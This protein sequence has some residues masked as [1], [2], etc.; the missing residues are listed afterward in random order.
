MQ[1][2][3]RDFTELAF[4]H[5]GIELKFEGEGINEKGIVIKGP[6]CYK[7]WN[8]ICLPITEQIANDELSLPIGPAITIEE[9][10]EVINLIN[11][12]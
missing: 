6:D 10:E 5:A 9:I 1:H 11:D 12:F 2:S 4:R 7:A 3:V 8:G